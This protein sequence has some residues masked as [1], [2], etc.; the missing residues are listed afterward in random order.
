MRNSTLSLTLLLVMISNLAVSQT[1]TWTGNVSND[2]ANNGNWGEGS[3]PTASSAVIIPTTLA[4]GKPWPVLVNADAVAGSLTLN[5]GS[6][7]D[8]NGHKMTVSGAVNITGATVA[9]SGA[10]AIRI[11]V[12]VVSGGSSYIRNSTFTAALDFKT[13]GNSVLYEADNTGTNT[14][15]GDVKFTIAATGDHNI[16]N[17]YRSLF[18]GNL[19]IERTAAGTTNVFTS[20]AATSVAVKGSF[21]YK[22]HSGG[23]TTIGGTDKKA[24]LEKDVNIDVETTGSNPSFT[25]RRLDNKNGTGG[26]NI[27]VI[28]PGTLNIIS[29]TL[30]LA[31]FTI[32]GK[33]GGVSNLA[34]NLISGV[35]TYSDAGTNAGSLYSYG[36][37]FDGASGFTF[38]GTVAGSFFESYNSA[39]NGNVYKGNAVFT[40]ASPADLTIGYHRSVTFE[41][42]LSV[43]RT[44][45]GGTG[46][47]VNSGS[48]GGDFSYTNEAGGVTAIGKNA[49]SVTVAGKV[50]I[51]TGALAGNPAFDLYK[52]S[53]E[54]TGGKIEIKNAGTFNIIDNNLSVTGMKVL[55]KNG[56]GSSLGNNVISGIFTYSDAGTNTGALYSYG[57]IF[58]GAS[59]FT[60]NGVAASQF[61]ESYNSAPDGNVYKGNA[62]FTTASPAPLTIG[63]HRSVTFEAGLS[64]TRTVAGATG[65]LVN[66]GSVG[67]NFSYTNEAGGGTTIGKDGG[68]VTVTG[69]VDILT[70]ASEGNPSFSLYKL[71]NETTG[72]KIE[73]KNAGTFN[74]ID[75]NLS[76]TGMKVLNKNGGG[77]SLGNNVISGIFTYSDAGT[78]TGALYSYGNIFDGASGFTFN[79]VAASQFFESYNSAPDGNVYK[80]NAVFTTASPAPLTIGYHRSVTF[81]AGLS[82]TRTVAGATGILVNNGSV[83]GNFSYANEAGGSTTIGKDGGS[84]TVTGKVDILTDAPEDNPSFSLY[85]LSNE[86]TGGEIEIK[87]AG[88]FNIIDNHLSVTEMKVL[89]KNGGGSS[90]GNNVIS[91]VFT[92][93]DAGT[94][95]GA[96][97]SYGNI[98]DGASDFTFNG[99]AAS[100]FFESYNSAP[101]GNVYKGNTSF[102]R[103]GAAPLSIAYHRT[104]EF[105]KSLTVNTLSGLS[106]GQPLR[107][108]G[109]S[110]GIFQQTGTQS[111]QLGG[112]I[113]DKSSHAKVT[114]GS[115]VSVSGAVTFTNGFLYTDAVNY[116]N[117]AG[118]SSGHSGAGN[119]SHVK[120]PVH[121][122]GTA[123]FTFPVGNGSTYHPVAISAPGGTAHVFSAE[124]KPAD[125]VNFN[126]AVFEAPLE[127]VSDQGYWEMQKLEGGNAVYLTLPYNVPAG[128]ITEPTD[129]HVAHWSGGKWESMGGVLEGG[130]TTTEG[131]VKTQNAI[132]SFSPF[133]LATINSE[134]N[135]L[136]VKLA[137]FSAVKEGQFVQLRWITTAETDNDYFEVEHSVDAR[138][139]KALDRIPANGTGLS[140]VKYTYLHAGPV[141]GNNYYRLR[142]AD[143]GGSLEYSDIRIINVAG[144][145]PGDLAVYPNPATDYIVISP[146][147]SFSVSSL[148]LFN[149]SGRKVAGYAG[150]LDGKLDVRELPSGLYFVKITYENHTV[151]SRRIVISR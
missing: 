86:T 97:Y 140:T 71:S 34:A 101:D 41:A 55:N 19:T 33:N 128:F 66:N 80:G 94:N 1:R 25:L 57:N 78:N 107:F 91:G 151:E 3:A 149:A 103:S 27:S 127:K 47:L 111:L 6:Q 21:T 121:K 96:L 145:I 123:A 12:G 92:Y 23:S 67:G 141:K 2:W 118:N 142:I 24:I 74:I 112:L 13:N 18:K 85:R 70:D 87:N 116:L 45:A 113:L 15:E 137:E 14:Y 95:T 30:K 53:N 64:V 77:S 49:G 119:D 133:T 124:Y 139:W 126:P 125:P 52:L 89:N 50:D 62:V 56:G 75:N 117:F 90:L 110:D 46:I 31:G 61:F 68:S 106:F 10:G 60:F 144:S 122:T 7:L 129:L 28:N 22:N 38:N 84:V 138:S 104:P 40:T 44:V 143:I 120:G 93:S 115:Q 5:A 132:S 16:S 59:G 108:A 54:T 83:G 51:L 136:P 150:S 37:T 9:N 36:N 82:V 29:D 98:F 73:I 148:D 4:A 146:S 81:E 43:T 48:V 11:D 79:G 147:S 20:N 114:L 42:G 76:V 69:K 134:A 99:A 26:G 72:G 35:F 63:Y 32:S 131:A 88:T 105:H 102:T 130:S 135:P 100:Q 65:I 17:I 58:D 8:V 109:S 39:P